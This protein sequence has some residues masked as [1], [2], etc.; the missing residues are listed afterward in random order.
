MHLPRFV[1]SSKVAKRRRKNLG[2]K[3]ECWYWFLQRNVYIH[4]TISKE[5]W[6]YRLKFFKKQ[7]LAWDIDFGTNSTQLSVEVIYEGN[8]ISGISRVKRL[9]VK[10]QKTYTVVHLMFTSKGVMPVCEPHSLSVRKIC[11][12]LLNNQWNGHIHMIAWLYTIIALILLES[13]SL[14]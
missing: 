6:L 2:V 4:T 12:L 11:D 9:H 8:Y 7:H 14:Y 10:G 1:S 3:E 13:L 5:S